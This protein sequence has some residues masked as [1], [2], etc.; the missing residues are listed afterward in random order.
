MNRT[1][2]AEELTRVARELAAL[3]EPAD[4][5]L[6]ARLPQMA[7]SEIAALIGNDW[8]QLNYAAK[9]YLEAMFSL[10]SI[11]DDYGMDSGSSIVAYFLANA[12]SWRGEVAK[13]VKKELSRRLKTRSGAEAVTAALGKRDFEA[14]AEIMRSTGVARNK[15]FVD[16]VAEWLGDQNPSFDEDGFLEALR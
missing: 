9:P 2:V 4:P 12:T 3:G 11:T 7:L 14:L 13:A 16:A 1:A 8:R 6:L 15:R 5:A 10:R